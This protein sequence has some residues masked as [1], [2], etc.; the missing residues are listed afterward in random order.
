[1][2]LVKHFGEKHAVNDVTFGIR[3]GECFGLLGPNG[4]GKS[5]TC[6]LILRDL[7]PTSGEILFPYANV[8]ASTPNEDAFAASRIGVCNQGDSL[9]E[10]LSA[11]EHMDQYLRLRLTT[12]YEPEMAG[13]IQDD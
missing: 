10:F 1:M 7:I 2:H 11:A 4:A 12:E 3:K 6:N 13:I 9:W 5:T 8:N